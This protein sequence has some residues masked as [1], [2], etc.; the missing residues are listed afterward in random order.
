MEKFPVQSELGGLNKSMGHY[1]AQNVFAVC[2]NID[3]A[4][5]AAG[6]NMLHSDLRVTV[7]EL[8]NSKRSC[9]N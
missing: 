5:G 8:R 9:Q 2:I 7:K 3:T 4:S 6:G 1:F